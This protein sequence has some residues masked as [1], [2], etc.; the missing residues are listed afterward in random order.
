MSSP[1]NVVKVVPLDGYRLDVEFADGLR[2]T[3]DMTGMLNASD[4]G[5][6]AP[7]KDQGLFRTAFVDGGAVRW[8]LDLDLAPDAMH[9][10]IKRNGEWK[11]T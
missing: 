5:V 10:E 7:L 6:F 9:D 3:V 4:P 2:G 11:L 1:W 8:H